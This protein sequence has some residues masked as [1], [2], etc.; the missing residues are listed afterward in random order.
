[1]KK[2]DENL[3]VNFDFKIYDTDIYDIW[4]LTHYQNQNN[5]SAV[6]FGVDGEEP[7]RYTVGKNIF[8]PVKAAEE[9]SFWG[10]GLKFGLG[11]VKVSS[12]KELSKG[13]H[14]VDYKMD[15]IAATGN[16]LY[17]N[18][19]IDCL[20]V[21]PKSWGWTPDSALT[22][23]SEKTEEEDNR[24]IWIDGSDM[25]VSKSPL[26]MRLQT[27][28]KGTADPMPED[29][30]VLYCAYSGNAQTD[31]ELDYDF[32]VKNKNNYDVWILANTTTNTASWG[33][34]TIQIDDNAPVTGNS[35]QIEYTAYTPENEHGHNMYWQRIYSNLELDAG[36]SHMDYGVTQPDSSVK[37]PMLMLDKIVIVPSDLDW[38]PSAELLPSQE[39]EEI[40]SIVIKD[41]VENFKITS[42]DDDTY[43]GGIMKNGK[44]YKFTTSYTNKSYTDTV[45]PHLFIARYHICRLII[46]IYS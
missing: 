42:S 39:K 5:I 22:R 13:K 41:K 30:K 43:G 8:D 17:Y 3:T 9:A 35:E 20:V 18:G 37:S 23:P 40:G 34:R 12:A 44:T 14:S 46:G 32:K 19:M 36:I 6:Y 27:T 31:V 24:A 10:G 4:A 7:E 33:K 1:M 38:V 28:I 26:L 15:P 11:W 25:N 2:S 45:T 16:N 21:V 29:N